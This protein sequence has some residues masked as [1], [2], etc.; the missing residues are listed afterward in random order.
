MSIDGDTLFVCFCFQFRQGSK[1][2]FSM[3][4]SSFFSVKVVQNLAMSRDIIYAA[5]HAKYTPTPRRAPP[6]RQPLTCRSRIGIHTICI[7]YI[8]YIHTVYIL[9]ILYILRYPIGG[10]RRR[11]QLRRALK[12]VGYVLARLVRYCVPPP[13]LFVLF[14]WACPF[15]VH[16]GGLHTAPNSR[17]LSRTR[18]GCSTVK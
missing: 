6:Y 13:Q 14:V 8:Y 11:A 17:S 1:K 18:R 4:S 10:R 9:Y 3:F 5:Q 16:R 12:V 2:I 7:L 15:G